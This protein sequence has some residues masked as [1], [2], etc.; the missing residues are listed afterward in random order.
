MRKVFKYKLDFYYQQTLLYL[1]TLLVYAGVVGS[2]VQDRFVFVLNDPIVYIIMLFVVVSAVVLLLNRLRDR[3]L[4]VEDNRIVFYNRYREQ[5]IPVSDIEWMHVGKEML[6]QTAGRFQQVVL[7]VKGRRRPFRIRLGRYE[8]D[9]E[10]LAE[11][12]R[13]AAR[14]PKGKRKQF[15]MRRRKSV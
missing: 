15:G 12:E 6:V 10:L 14:V 11:M 13:I 7:K 5:E 9:R 1:V 3:R 4:I 2:V 8:R